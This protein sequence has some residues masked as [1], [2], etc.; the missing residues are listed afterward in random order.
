MNSRRRIASPRLG[1]CRRYFSTRQLQQAFGVWGMGVGGNC[2]AQTSNRQCRKGVKRYTFTTSARLPLRCQ[3]R[4]YHCIAV[5]DAV[6]GH[7]KTRAPQQTTA[8]AA[9]IHSIN[10]SASASSVGGMSRPS[11]LAV[12][13]LIT[14]SN[15][16]G[17]NT[18]RSRGLAPWRT[19]PV[20][21]PTWRY[22]SKRLGE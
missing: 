18:G 19:F 21:M 6:G 22:P 9:M 10:S 2:G 3:H 11:A 8:H 13:M 16:V 14:N 4:T 1:L 5:T 15:L 12:F 7:K 20:Y 17:C